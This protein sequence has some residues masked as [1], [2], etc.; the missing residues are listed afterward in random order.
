MERQWSKN[1]YSFLLCYVNTS[2]HHKWIKFQTPAW[3]W[4]GTKWVVVV[5]QSVSFLCTCAT[6]LEGDF[7]SACKQWPSEF[8]QFFLLDSAR[9]VEFFQFPYIGSLEVTLVLRI[10]SYMVG[11]ILVVD[12][13][14]QA[15]EAKIIVS[16]MFIA[17]TIFGHMAFLPPSTKCLNPVNH[18][19]ICVTQLYNSSLMIH[20]LNQEINQ[21]VYEKEKIRPPLVLLFLLCIGNS[22]AFRDLFSLSGAFWTPLWQSTKKQM[23]MCEHHCTRIFLKG[24][25]PLG[26]SP[27]S[28]SP[29]SS[30]Y[31]CLPL[32]RNWIII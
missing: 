24:S 7:E 9:S 27:Q 1:I 31:V 10:V 26:A 11:S 4:T 30:G 14:F 25:N 29:L 17:Q 5:A 6:H 13:L 21:H 12:P 18:A 28:C 32:W 19:P 22:L 15:A 8:T 20:V 16:T 3:Y 2:S 23:A